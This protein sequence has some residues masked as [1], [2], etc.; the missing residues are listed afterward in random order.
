VL[1]TIEVSILLDDVENLSRGMY[2]LKIKTNQGTVTKKFV[3]D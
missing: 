2:L 1:L 3:K